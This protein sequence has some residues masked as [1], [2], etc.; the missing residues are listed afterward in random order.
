MTE[1]KE[2][3]WIFTFEYA[4]VAKVGGLGEVPANQAKYLKE[5]FE[6]TVFIPSHGQI[7]RLKE[8]TE[9]EQLPFICKQEFDIK[10]L[11]MAES[12]IICEISYFKCKLNGIN[13]ILL[14][15]ENAFTSKYLDDTIV[16]HPDTFD[17]KML[18]FS[19]GMR[20]YVRNLIIN[21]K[22]AIPDIIHMHDY[23]V[24]IPFICIKQ[25]LIKNDLDVPSIITIHLLTYPKKKLDYFYACGID[26]SPIKILLNEGF[27]LLTI[28]EIFK[29]CQE[30]QN[31]TAESNLPTIEKI[32]AV[33]ADLVTTVSESYLHSD[34]IPNLG[35]DLIKFKSDFV[36]DGCDWDYDESYKNIID[37]LGNEICEV[38]QIP[39]RSLITRNHMKDYLLTYKISHLKQSPLV[40]SE[41]VLAAINEISH[42]DPFMK[43]GGVKS[44]DKTGP[45][46]I[47]T[48]RI[49][50]QKGFDTILKAIPEV[51]KVI[52][53]AKFLLLIL[54]TE[55]SLS[56][57]KE[58]AQFV[59]IYPNNLRIVFGIAAEIFQIAHIGSNAYCALSRW[60]P[61]GIMALEAMASKLPVIATKVGGLQE[62]IIDVRT[63]PENG[64]GILIEKDNPIQFSEAL[65]SIFKLAEISNSMN[66]N[67]YVSVAN[68]IP[69]KVIKNQVLSDKNYYNKIREN[70]YRRVKE[71]FRWQIVTK[72]L[73]DLYKK[74]MKLH[75][76]N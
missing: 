19:I 3:V 69:D 37:K 73:D 71:H 40:K 63:D 30:P 74:V 76:K 20:D 35:K 26:K 59:K 31:E 44:F 21:H 32:G 14:A 62:S 39:S 36:W 28:Q 41:K 25:E 12:K 4:G 22:T 57:I 42:R 52:P 23:H 24:V 38:L 5:N 33:I 11:G 16:Y 18:L 54:P 1:E 45:L 17:L 6:V 64:T 15:G 72:K 51:I 27:K 56:E 55:Y 43:N 65:I 53:E 9:L 68:S 48:G 49:S 13:I 67:Q 8:S 58:Y 66:D 2:K 61:F 34:I 46:I 60:E 29:L 10:H 47:A 7:E 50:R 70:C 75:I